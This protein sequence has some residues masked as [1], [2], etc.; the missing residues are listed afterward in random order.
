M[1]SEINQNAFGNSEQRFA[2]KSFFG[3]YLAFDT[4]ENCVVQKKLNELNDKCFLIWIV[5]SDMPIAYYSDQSDRLHF[6]NLYTLKSAESSELLVPTLSLRPLSWPDCYAFGYQDG[7][8]LCALPAGEI[9]RHQVPVQEWEIFQIL[10]EALVPPEKLEDEV[11]VVVTSCGRHD[12]LEMTLDSFVKYNTYKKIREIIVVEDGD[13]DPSAVCKK[14]GANLVRVGARHGQSY[15]IDLAYSFVRTPFIFH[16]ED[17]WEFYRGGFIEKSF[18]V[19]KSDP[20]C[21]NV[22]LRAWSDTQGHPLHFKTEDRSFG[23][24]SI[25][26]N[27][28]WGG[29]TWNPGLRRLADYNRIGPFSMKMGGNREMKESDV[30][31][32]CIEL[33]YRGVILDEDGYVRHLGHGRHVD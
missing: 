19:L 8:Y 22:W 7:S 17:D 25:G 11:T 14:F 28:A 15:A 5:L 9:I 10:T 31:L 21:I 3:K 2:I 18:D 27:Q 26:Y 1:G 24:L 6:I 33:G 4:L 32:K 20:S 13:A 30:S 23:V 29:F 16:C 12:L